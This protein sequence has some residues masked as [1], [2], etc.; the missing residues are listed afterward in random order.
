MR[1]MTNTMI[2]QLSISTKFEISDAQN[3]MK[4]ICGQHGLIVKNKNKLSFQHEFVHLAPCYSQVEM[5]Y[6][7]TK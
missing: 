3:W 5:S 7:I 6:L 2:N 4:N 1:W